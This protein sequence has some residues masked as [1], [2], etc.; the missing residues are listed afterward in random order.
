MF[1][2]R[3]LE[4]ALEDGKL[5]P[6]PT[7]ALQ[8]SGLLCQQQLLHL[9][10][11]AERLLPVQAFLGDHGDIS[12]IHWVPLPPCHSLGGPFQAASVFRVGLD[13]LPW[14]EPLPILVEV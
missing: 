9:L 5:L 2:G 12:I 14:T 1:G 10:H 7:G 8:V 11:H 13:I 3:S 4:V 6:E